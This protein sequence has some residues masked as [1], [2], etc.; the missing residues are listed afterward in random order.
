MKNWLRQLRVAPSEH[1]VLIA[2]VL[3]LLV[4]HGFW[5]GV[6]VVDA[7]TLG[8]LGV[9]VVLVLRPL[10]K[11]ANVA[12]VAGVEFREELHAGEESAQQVEAGL[13]EEE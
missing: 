12:G 10:L 9:V 2:F 7:Y 11:S 5:P 1:P 6:F 4:V 13:E 8:L 3:V